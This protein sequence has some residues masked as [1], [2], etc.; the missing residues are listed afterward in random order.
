LRPEQSLC[1][2][3]NSTLLLPPHRWSNGTCTVLHH[4]V[5]E[6]QQI[7]AMSDNSVVGMASLVIPTGI[8]SAACGA[9]TNRWRASRRVASNTFAADA[10]SLTLNRERSAAEELALG[11][12]CLHLPPQSHQTLLQVS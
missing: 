1:P 6:L 4:L 3:T 2:I 8:H 5:Q 11:F 12:N 10:P 7:P 9:M